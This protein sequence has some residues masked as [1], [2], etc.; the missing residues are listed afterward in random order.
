[1][2]VRSSD[3]P[4]QPVVCIV[5]DD[6]AIGRAL[7][8]LVESLGLRARVY[9]SPRGLLDEDRDGDADFLLLDVQ[10]PGMSGFDL[11]DRLVASGRGA[12]VVFITANLDE[13]TRARAARV[14]AACLE[15]PFDDQDLLTAIE[16]VLD[17]GI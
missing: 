2:N 17:L 1:M 16:R 7:S 10:L 15:K 12:P 11:H 3:P 13:R 5:D 4:T 6:V 9:T 14:D 8:R